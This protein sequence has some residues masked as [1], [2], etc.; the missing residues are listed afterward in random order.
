MYI[1]KITVYNLFTKTKKLLFATSNQNKIDEAKRCLSNLGI[2]VSPIEDN[3]I[4]ENLYEIQNNNPEE[5]M[6]SKLKQI[7]KVVF[8]PVIVD[9][10]SFSIEDFNGFPGPYTKYVVGTLGLSEICNLANGK[11]A[12]MTSYIGFYDGKSDFRVFKGTLS[13]KIIKEF[14]LS[15]FFNGKAQLNSIFIPDGY[16]QTADKLSEDQCF[17]NHRSLALKEL[18]NYLQK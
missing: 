13:G 18:F 15:S 17:F 14:N 9:D 12:T 4:M 8:E 6:L 16:S 2:D 5:V 7:S 3:Q 10:F 1:V 11:S